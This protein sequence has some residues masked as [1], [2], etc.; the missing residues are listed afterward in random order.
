MVSASFSKSQQIHQNAVL[1]TAVSY[2][3][4]AP[5]AGVTILHADIT[6]PSTLNKMMDAM[7]EEKADLVV[8]DGAPEGELVSTEEARMFSV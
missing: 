5:L 8:C 4:Q 7:E 1:T 6:V 2:A 3:P